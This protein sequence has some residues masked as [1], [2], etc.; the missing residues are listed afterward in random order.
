VTGSALDAGARPRWPSTESSST[1]PSDPGGERSV[2]ETLAI[3]YTGVY[4]P[5][6][7]LTVVSPNGDGIAERQQLSFKLVRPSTVTTS[8][9]GPEA[10][11]IRPNGRAG[12]GGLQGH[13]AQLTSRRRQTEPLGRWRWVVTAVDD[14]GRKSSVERSFWLNDTLGYMRVAPRPRSCADGDET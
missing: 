5:P 8:L 9:I 13:L 3:L 7:A 10:R 4:A 1:G 14:L 2:A 11:P 6:P 12:G